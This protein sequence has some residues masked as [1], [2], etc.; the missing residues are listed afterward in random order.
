MERFERNVRYQPWYEHW[1]R[2]YFIKDL[3]CE[4]KVCDI[5]CGDGYGSAL[6]A[7]NA[8]S[9]SGV[10]VDKAT[11]KSAINNY[12]KMA[13]NLKFHTFDALNTGFTDNQFDIVV[14]FETLEH[15]AEHERLI[16]E[17]KRILKPDGLLI[18]STPD[19]KVYSE[20]S[21][22]NHY[23]VKELNHQEFNTLIADYFDFT[24]TYGQQLQLMSIIEVADYDKRYPKGQQ[25][26]V[27]P[28]NEFVECDNHP[29]ANYLIKI[30]S[31]SKQALESLHV[32]DF[33][34]FSDAQNHLYQ[35][36]QEQIQRLLLIDKENRDMKDLLT[37][38]NSTINY[39]KARLGL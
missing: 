18:I 14:S 1:H 36:Y 35:H 20:E 31:N 32:P 33:H 6:L 19:K 21:H 9:V 25:I 30:C 4:K 15:L 11:I 7:Q 26:F 39:L 34:S 16:T 8:E 38:Q 5:A 37:E 2:Y 28:D 23:H 17:F 22:H 24:Y 3:V 13:D 12:S 10:D 29:Q 27:M